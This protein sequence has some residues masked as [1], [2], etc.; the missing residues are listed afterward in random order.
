[1]GV[2]EVLPNNRNALHSTQLRDFGACRFDEAADS[3][4]SSQ[5]PED[6]DLE[7]DVGGAYA[8][9]TLQHHM[10][11]ASMLPFI[12]LVTGRAHKLLMCILLCLGANT[13]CQSQIKVR[14]WDTDFLW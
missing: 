7:L 12:S 4:F 13:L 2:C 14:I 10:Q 1:M 11:Y 5:G 8:Y 6:V 3:D 9:F